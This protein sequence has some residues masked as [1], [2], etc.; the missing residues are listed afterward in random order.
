M[1]TSLELADVILSNPV[2]AD[3]SGLT[4]EEII[5]QLDKEIEALPPDIKNLFRK[6]IMAANL[7]EFGRSIE[8]A[9][10]R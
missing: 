10:R 2:K 9:R 4:L 8:R 6:R 3:I 5:V 7:L 1:N